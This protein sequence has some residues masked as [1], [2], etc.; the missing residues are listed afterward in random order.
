MTDTRPSTDADLTSLCD[1]HEQAFGE[2]EGPEIADL[3]RRLLVDETARPLLSLVAE[4]EHEIVGHVL[5]TNVLIERSP[6]P[7]RA[8]ILAPLA[9][10]PDWQKRGIGGGLIREGLTRLSN[11]DVGLVF[12][13][14]DPA[15]YGRF[16]FVPATD[17]GLVAP[18]PIPAEHPDA[19]RVHELTPGLL[20][21]VRGNVECARTLSRP[22]YW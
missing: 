7:A 4:A 6:V 19:W 2:E 13:L 18:H 1:L 5:F 8:R 21:Q 9:V 15:Y 12:V 3:V 22:E 20:G 14:G 11:A 10:L 17:R 16:G